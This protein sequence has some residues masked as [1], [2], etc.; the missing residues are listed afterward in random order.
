MSTATE[1]DPQTA[2]E[3]IERIGSLVLVYGGAIMSLTILGLL[4]WLGVRYLQRGTG[5]AS[6]GVYGPRFWDR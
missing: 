2:E 1:T 5:W 4:I 6:S 3:A